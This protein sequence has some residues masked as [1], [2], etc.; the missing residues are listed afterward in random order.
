MSRLVLCLALV[1]CHGSGSSPATGDGLTLAI[2]D[3]SMPSQIGVLGPGTDRSFL[4]TTISLANG[5]T[6]SLSI[7]FPLF[8]V[9]TSTGL[10]VQASMATA[11]LSTRCAED[12]SLAP[13]GATQCDLV[14]A[15]PNSETA[16]EV[17]YLDA[18]TMMTS[19]ASLP[20]AMMMNGG[21]GFSGDGCATLATF[22]NMLSSGCSSCMHG[23]PCVFDS[24]PCSQSEFLCYT[25]CLHQAN[26]ACTCAGMCFVSDACKQS[27]GGYS[28]CAATHCVSQCQ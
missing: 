13:G 11:L 28:Q 27:F 10:Q 19:T 1:A 4:Q 8:S 5:G 23:N 3:V 26:T 9:Q 21:P 18:Q 20:S 14:F 22:H 24:D 25:S 6:R 2:A 17:I 16:L 15:V 12:Q 7:A